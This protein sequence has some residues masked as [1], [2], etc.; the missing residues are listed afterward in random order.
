VLAADVLAA[1]TIYFT[2]HLGSAAPFWDGSIWS[3]VSLSELSLALDSNSGHTGYHQSGKN[4]DLFL[5]YN[6]GSPRLVSG[7]AWTSDTARAGAIA[8]LNGIWLNTASM[9][10]RYGTSSGD[11]ASI[12]ANRLTYVGTF[13]ATANGQ[14]GMA[15]KPSAASGG[16]NNVLGLYNAYNRVSVRAME[17]DSAASWTYSSAT[18][19]AG[20]NSS[21]NRIS[22]VDGLQESFIF[23]YLEC[24][25]APTGAGSGVFGINLD[26]TTA[27][28]T[29]IG[30]QNVNGSGPSSPAGEIFLPQL[31]FHYL[32]DMEAATAGITTTYPG[33]PYRALM[34]ML[35]M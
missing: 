20:N 25:G 27:T 6:A 24:Q 22:F 23:A 15:F 10:V 18:W 7:P 30:N 3:L 31:G 34:V 2:P 19:R 5:D 35:E 33:A 11:T 32:Q 16:S 21:S 13:R 17:R 1:T 9:T 29:V 28:P 26:S 4:F 12:G 14:T 8:R